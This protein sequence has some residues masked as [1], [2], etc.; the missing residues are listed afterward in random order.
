MYVPGNRVSMLLADQVVDPELKTLATNIPF[1]VMS[2]KISCESIHAR[3][4]TNADKNSRA[5]I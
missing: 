2:L 1:R 5:Y 4:P 3:A